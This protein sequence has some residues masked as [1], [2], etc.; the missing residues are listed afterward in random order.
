MSST[1]ERSIGGRSR[2]Q[3]FSLVEVIMFIVIISVW[4]VIV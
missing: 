3:G 2:C 4:W 1:E